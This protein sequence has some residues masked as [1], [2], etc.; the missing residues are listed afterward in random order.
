M[1]ACGASAGEPTAQ[2][3]APGGAGPSATL[4]RTPAMRRQR[5]ILR[6]AVAGGLLL[7]AVAARP[8]TAGREAELERLRA[9]IAT[10]QARLGTV[11]AQDSGI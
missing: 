4:R 2:R 7:L 3:P 9:E 1:A 5:P 11:H 6:A 8:Q 10:L